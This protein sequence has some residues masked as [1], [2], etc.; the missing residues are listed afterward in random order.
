M[1]VYVQSDL[2]DHAGRTLVWR[3]VAQANRLGERDQQAGNEV[4]D[5]P[6]RTKPTT[7]PNH[8]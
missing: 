8:R 6:L 7:S 2:L 5:R 1:N 4:P 3:R